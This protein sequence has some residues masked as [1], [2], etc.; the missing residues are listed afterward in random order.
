M[1]LGHVVQGKGHTLLRHQIAPGFFQQFQQQ[2]GHC[3]GEGVMIQHVCPKCKAKKVVQVKEEIKID[4][5]K[6]MS[7]GYVT[8]IRGGGHEAPGMRSGN[9]VA[10]IVSEPHSVFRRDGV[11]LRHTVVL[12]LKE[13][14]L[15][16][17]RDISHLDG[18]LVKIQQRDVTTPFTV[19]TFKGEGM[20]SLAVASG[21]STSSERGDL[22]V[23]FLIRFPETLSSKQ[24]AEVTR[25]LA[26]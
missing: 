21:W 7:E 23:D 1:F 19:L 8:T 18:H 25:L 5:P 22:F 16:F 3:D 26:G 17:S 14:L 10:T 12:T 4:I 11:H 20:P 2:C 9:I 13:A 24:Q 6:G 15:G